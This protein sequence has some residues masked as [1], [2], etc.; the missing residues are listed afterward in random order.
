MVKLK[1]GNVCRVFGSVPN[2]VLNGDNTIY[3]SWGRRRV[4][5]KEQSFL[6]YL[7]LLKGEFLNFCMVG[8]KGPDT[9]RF[10]SH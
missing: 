3:V 2:I 4:E 8:I 10:F 6:H 9:E 5:D 1:L 7:L